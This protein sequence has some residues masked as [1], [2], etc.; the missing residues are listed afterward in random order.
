MGGEFSHQS[1][2]LSES[3]DFL[4]IKSGGIYVDMTL[5]GGG[6]S[7]E[8]L[9]RRA[10]CR[11][12][13]ID[14]DGAAIKAASEL[15]CEFGGRFTAARGNF[16]DILG[17]LKEL[18]TEKISGAIMDLG[19]SSH[20]LD[21]ADRGFSY[22]KDAALDMRM[23]TRDKITAA[24]IIN[25]KAEAEL[26]RII[27]E[28]GEER[29]AKR[30]AAYIVAARKIKRIETTG[31]LVD[32]IKSAVPAGA[33]RDGPHPAKRTFQ[34][35]RIAVNNELNILKEAIRDVFSALERG[36]RLAVI[37]F[38]SLEDRIVK[39][40]FKELSAGCICPRDFPIC[41]CGL[42]PKARVITAKPVAPSGAE[43]LEN[44]RSRSA[45]LRV[46]EKL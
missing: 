32:I 27:R 42:S 41:A 45:K 20:Q 35:V 39:T 13:G 43:V 31:E 29:W 4:N 37:S 33:R 28:Y 34:A 38:H 2:L 3:V 24:D 12:I 21:A 25:G 17:I 36:G 16:K 46:A 10:D 9:K 15:L 8:I 30:I 23:D 5:G 22:M 18:G 6:H 19:V 1:V 26:S 11:V 44:P 40:E 14:R 7:L